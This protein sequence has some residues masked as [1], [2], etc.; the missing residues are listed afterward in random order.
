ML[1][2]H[3]TIVVFM[4]LLLKSNKGDVL[5]KFR[6]KPEIKNNLNDVFKEIIQINYHQNPKH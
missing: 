4:K 1:K 3:S 5:Y 6:R 2:L